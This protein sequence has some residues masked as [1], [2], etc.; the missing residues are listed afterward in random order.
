MRI[1]NKIQR[2]RKREEEEEEKANY[3]FIYKMIN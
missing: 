1:K 2:D 3:K